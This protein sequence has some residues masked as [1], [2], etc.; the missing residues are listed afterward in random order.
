MNYYNEIDPWAAA[1]LRQ[2][3]AENLIPPGEIDTRSIT[4]VQP[5]DLRG[6]N[7][8]HFFAGIAGWSL[9]L[10]LAGWPDDRPVWTGSCP[11]QPYSVAGKS[12]GDADERNLWPAF[13]NLIRECRPDCIFGEQVEAAISHGWLD[14]LRADLEGEN[15]A[16]G[17]CTL[18]AHSAGADHQRQ[19]LYWVVESQSEQHDGSRDARGGRGQSANRGADGRADSRRE[20]DERRGESA[21]GEVEREAHERERGGDAAGDSL[22]D[23]PMADSADGPGQS[24]E[25]RAAIRPIPESNGCGNAA[26]TM[27][28]GERP[29][30]EGHAGD[31]DR[32]GESGRELPVEVGPTAPRGGAGPWS[33]SAAILCRDGKRR[34]I[35]AQPVFQSVVDG[36]PA[37]MGAGWAEGFTDAEVAAIGRAAGG[38]PLA[39]GIP[40]RAAILKG[41]G[42]AIVPQVAAQFIQAFVTA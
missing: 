21:G 25:P 15:Y 2:L 34:R 17:D 38:F 12:K 1:W 37:G 6:F 33:G 3:I 16:V 8:C 18:G 40:H 29:G 42:N 9:A 13:F 20:R 7:Q 19:R 24:S 27:A 22:P 41:A 28:D 23:E 31:G 10:R 30:L 36:L 26:D 39:Q 32:G 14:G 35:P 5:I 11:C 4:D